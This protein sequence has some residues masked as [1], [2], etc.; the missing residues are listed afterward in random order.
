M[1]IARTPGL[2]FLILL[3]ACTADGGPTVGI[4]GTGVVQGTLYTDLDANGARTALDQPVA[5][6]RVSVVLPGTQ[7]EV[8]RTVT[9][10]QGA[11][12]TAV[13]VGRYELS[14]PPAVLGDSLSISAVVI[15]DVDV[16]PGNLVFTLGVDD[17]VRLGVGL[18]YPSPSIAELR[19]LPARS[20]VNID[21]IALTAS[22]PF[23][24]RSL[25]IRDETGALRVLDVVGDAIIPGDSVQLLGR[26]G[27]S[28]GQPVLT[29]TRALLLGPG[30]PPP[31]VLIGT[32]QVPA[33]DAGTLDAELVEV[34]VATVD[35]TDVVA[36][37]LHLTVDDG[38]GPATVVLYRGAGF[39]FAD[40]PTGAVID[41]TGV[42]VPTDTGAPTDWVLM[43]RGPADI[44]IRS[45]P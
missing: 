21:G 12:S 42:L 7:T 9:G 45:V 37:D 20:R 16:D 6:A 13:D 32:G 35:T 40:Y 27:L 3:A 41:A 15:N 11:F 28:R 22:G 26:T 17:T 44:R 8:S 30:A 19:T 2:P 43:P 14:L 31:T 5:G 34:V 25:H 23:G 38:S 39:D 29:D 36:G 1:R 18:A 24:G 4:D 33:A 10:A